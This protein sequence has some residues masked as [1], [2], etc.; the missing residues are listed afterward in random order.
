M[1][2][3]VGPEEEQAIAQDL[4]QGQL[5]S[6]V[7]RKYNR[8]PETVR[9]IRI[10]YDIPRRKGPG[11]HL[12]LETYNAVLQD[13][14]N[15][16]R[17]P[18]VGRKYNVGDGVVYPIAEHHGIEY[19]RSHQPLSDGQEARIEYGF[20]K[21][22]SCREIA[23]E[24]GLP[25]GTVYALAR[26]KGWLPLRFPDI[27]D[28]ERQQIEGV[29]KIGG[30]EPPEIALLMDRSVASIQHIWRESGFCAQ[31]PPSV[32]RRR[33][34]R[35]EALI[36]MKK[37]DA[38][39]IAHE[40]G[41]APFQVRVLRKRLDAQPLPN[42]KK[43]S[44]PTTP[45]RARRARCKLGPYRDGN[46][47]S[48]FA[49]SKISKP[50]V[51]HPPD[52]VLNE[53]EVHACGEAWDHRAILR[54]PYVNITVNTYMKGLDSFPATPSFAEFASWLFGGRRPSGYY[55]VPPEI[56]DLKRRLTVN[57]IAAAA[58][59]NMSTVDR[60]QA[61]P[62]TKKAFD[63][64]TKAFRR[65]RRPP[66]SPKWTS[67]PLVTQRLMLRYVACS[68]REAASLDVWPASNINPW[69]GHVHDARESGCKTQLVWFVDGGLATDA[70]GGRWAKHGVVDL[71]DDELKRLSQKMTSD[72]DPEARLFVPPAWMWSF[73][74]VASSRAGQVSGALSA[75]RRKL[76]QFSDTL[77]TLFD[78]MFLENVLPRPTWRSTRAWQKLRGLF[79]PTA[80]EETTDESP[81]NAASPDSQQPP[82]P[83]SI[84]QTPTDNQP[85]TLSDQQAEKSVLQK[86]F[87]FEKQ[88]ADDHPAYNRLKDAQKMRQAYD[89][90]NPVDAPSDAKAFQ[91]ARR[92]ARKH[93]LA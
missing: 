81:Q 13:L 57:G 29:F 61:N 70:T 21:G 87:E 44:H 34:K 9:R 41:L 33:Q 1:A 51:E 53:N 5:S 31:Y 76:Q 93:G 72:D 66:K 8:C 45:A 79:P 88:W 49:P 46:G 62:E 7:A 10:K 36:R 54:H 65:G 42:E 2:D 52:Y 32:G 25:Y 15:G 67:L 63:E 22:K 19:S 4:Q 85:V 90:A 27:D 24:E 20:A 43:P 18:D 26:R 56:V 91:N 14:Q 73:R 39:A 55:L 40:L 12:P 80:D 92:W 28:E 82:S 89:A 3:S 50:S 38:I 83:P 68:T 74:K 47:R 86:R 23:D 6:H 60:W 48:A 78:V 69:S 17:P 58:E 16:Q 37:L 35:A 77:Y 30:W 75:L 64:A 84:P 71:S 11:S 59:L